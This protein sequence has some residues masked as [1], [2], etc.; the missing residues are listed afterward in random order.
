[1]LKIPFRRHA[2][3]KTAQSRFYT[4]KHSAMPKKFGLEIIMRNI[5]CLWAS[6]GLP[7][8]RQ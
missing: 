7:M 2:A 6:G 8:D 4:P 5:D 1:V 3:H